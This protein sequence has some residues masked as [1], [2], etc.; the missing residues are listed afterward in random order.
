MAKKPTTGK[1]VK[2][3]AEP[4]VKLEK[5]AVPAKKSKVKAD[6]DLI[7]NIQSI[8]QQLDDVVFNAEKFNN[9]NMSAGRRIRKAMQAIKK[10]AQTIR[11]GVQ[12][13]ITASK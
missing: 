5:K 6:F 13:I 11:F 7:E 12:D 8:Q 10:T 2:L 1:V 3:T 4:K 9:G